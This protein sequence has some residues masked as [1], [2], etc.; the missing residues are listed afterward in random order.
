MKEQN[1]LLC[2][3]IAV[4]AFG[5]IC[6][7]DEA[8]QAER[9]EAVAKNQKDSTN[10]L[11]A[12]IDQAC[13]KEQMRPGFLYGE[14]MRYLGSG[15]TSRTV[16]VPDGRHIW[17]N[18][19]TGLVF[20]SRPKFKMV[21]KYADAEVEAGVRRNAAAR[22]SLLEHLGTSLHNDSPYAQ[23]E[24]FEVAAFLWGKDRTKSGGDQAK[25][26]HVVN[27]DEIAHGLMNNEALASSTRI[28]A[29]LYL[30]DATSLDIAPVLKGIV[31]SLPH[32]KPSDEL[33][34]SLRDICAFVP[35]AAKVLKD[36]DESA[37]P[38]AN[39]VDDIV[40]DTSAL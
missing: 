21:E 10:E 9:V 40:V 14:I 37:K 36:V 34:K 24:I 2:A 5:L 17:T 1:H 31:S 22:Q 33:L 25:E 39:D 18:R 6:S 27:F 15:P 35:E 20:G 8:V 13:A 3:L 4:C 28:R 12:V 11:A 16:R 23:R 26:D 32:E 29:A 38:K 30:R 7:A 19:V